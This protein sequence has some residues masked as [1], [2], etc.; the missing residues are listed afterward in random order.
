MTVL[1]ISPNAAEQRIFARDMKP[2]QV[3]ITKGYKGPGQY[4]RGY[5][6]GLLLRSK[7]V[8]HKESCLDVLTINTATGS[9]AYLPALTEVEPFKEA[10][11]I[12]R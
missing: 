11:L 3:F 9:I 5:P 8:K 4:I 12:V 6:A 10:S 7:T 1:K 2:M